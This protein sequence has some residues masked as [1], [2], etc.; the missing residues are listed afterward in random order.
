MS[1]R[2]IGRGIGAQGLVN[3]E[4]REVLISLMSL[5]PGMPDGLMRPVLQNLS[6][7]ITNKSVAYRMNS[8]F[9][10]AFN[11]LMIM[12]ISNIMC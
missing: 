10:R 9:T 4:I 12:L 3:G 6:L 8:P 1:H 5:R 2:D 11:G 7:S